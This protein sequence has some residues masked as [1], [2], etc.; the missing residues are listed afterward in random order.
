MK[1][2]RLAA[3]TAFGLT[4]LCFSLPNAY[5]ASEKKAEAAYEACMNKAVS[6]ADMLDCGQ[7]YLD[8]WDKQLNIN[9]KKAKKACQEP[10]DGKATPDQCLKKLVS[11]ERSWISYRDQMAEMIDYTSGGTSARLN[12]QGFL[13]E[14]TKKQ[15]QTLGGL[16]IE[17]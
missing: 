2:S 10:A 11:M 4:T 14:A 3:L 9:Y 16:S 13:I 5:A 7:T 1:I 12:T 17:E 6:T 8:F 15:A